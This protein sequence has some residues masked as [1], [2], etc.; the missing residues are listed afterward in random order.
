MP[1]W[2]DAKKEFFEAGI[3][4]IKNMGEWNTAAIE[5]S[6]KNLATEKNIKIGELQMIFRI[7]LV[8]NKMGPAVFAIAALIG[9]E[10]TVRRIQKAIAS[11]DKKI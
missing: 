8:G 10:E 5:E 2:D 7:M 4:L 6:F 1:K 9:K 11:F 3:G